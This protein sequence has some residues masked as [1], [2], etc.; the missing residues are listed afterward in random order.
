LRGE[1]CS[2][3]Q[4]LDRRTFLKL[5]GLAAADGA[6]PALL[7]AENAWR[8]TWKSLTTHATPLWFQDA[9]FG[10][11]FT[12]GVYSVP[13]FGYE[14]YS[15]DMYI[16]GTA[17]NKF[18]NLV[19]GPPSRF[20]YKDFIPRFHAE[21][22][23]A[24]E[25]AQLFRKSGAKFAGP[26]AEHCDGFSMWDSQ[27]NPWNAARMGPCRDVVGEMSRAIRNE[28]LT[29]ITTFHHQWLWGWYPTMNPSL[30][31]SD[32]RYRGLYGPP[33]PGSPFDYT[34]MPARTPPPP[35]EFQDTFIA[36]TRE[37]IDKYHPSLIYFDSRLNIIDEH[38]LAELFA[39]YY[40]QGERWH[41]ELAITYKSKDVPA[42]A[43][44]LDI[45]RGRLAE[46]TPYNWMTDNALDW[47][48]WCSNQNPDYKSP[49][50]IVTELVD[51]VS[52]NGNLLLDIPPSADGVIPEPVVELL[53][54]V[55]RWL[56]VNGE[57]IYGTRPWK[58]YGEGPTHVKPGNFGDEKSLDFV[59]EDI[60]FTTRPKTLYAT[61]LDWPANG[62]DLVIK[63]LGT[64][65]N[66][67]AKGEIAHASLLG[68]DA[69]L[70]WKQ[71]E[72]ELRIAL[73]PEKPGEFAYVFKFSLN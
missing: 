49:R 24:E 31:C 4:G 29:F 41:E 72:E 3:T 63:S 5:A 2:I 65:A 22:F 70:T 46:L 40:N 7:H 6:L 67:L 30:D 12:W 25:W 23:N 18:H 13:A 60:R 69:K 44:I 68:S 16:E 21:K 33:A 35:Q 45:E 73:P 26:V 47:K 37:V 59:A 61:A 71:N 19:Y 8:P 34:H 38:R 48:S 43:A 27:V 9:K 17:C 11:Y 10:I 54:A 1:K 50:R 36:K 39:Y 56:D 66:L 55:G 51:I 28:G 14:W 20:G 58:T 32:R 62:G 42:G 57:A 53:H 15:R 52:K 64:R